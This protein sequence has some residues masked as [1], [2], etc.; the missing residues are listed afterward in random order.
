MTADDLR[1]AML[2]VHTSPLDQPGTGDAGGMNV[3][4][5]DLA[6]AMARRGAEVSIYT[7]ATAPDMPDAVPLTA[8]V[9]VRHVPAGP[10]EE[11]DKRDLPGQVH[12]F[13]DAVLRDVADRGARYDVVHSHY[14]LSG[15]VGLRL[16]ARW[17]VPLVHTMHTLARVKNAVLPPG[18][19]P[20]PAM[21]IAG[22]DEVVT[23]A[24]A[25]IAN[26]PQ[27]AGELV[28]L[29]GAESSRVRVIAPGVDHELFL[30][31]DAE[32]RVR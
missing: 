19:S 31:G 14:W 13:A 2:S 27:E 20:E 3:Y 24:D 23:A 29:Y 7:R 10:Q 1:V 15:Q 25:L 6:T 11:M 16:T 18:D 21:R 9:T 12:A 30:P 22:E 32:D 8:G 5:A 26:T 4:V 17:Q 28:E